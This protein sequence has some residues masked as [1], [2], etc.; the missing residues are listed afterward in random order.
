MRIILLTV[1]VNMNSYANKVFFSI[2]LIGT[3]YKFP[4]AAGNLRQYDSELPAFIT[5]KFLPEPS[6]YLSA[7]SFSP[8]RSDP[9]LILHHMELLQLQEHPLNGVFPH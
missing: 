5:T 3:N 9:V 1:I 8:T 6:G 4:I 7:S 2:L